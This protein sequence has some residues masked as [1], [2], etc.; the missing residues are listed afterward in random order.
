MTTKGA[1]A[2]TP[3]TRQIFANVSHH[4]GSS[5]LPAGGSCPPSPGTRGPTGE[6]R[7]AE[8]GAERE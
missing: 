1:F 4:P 7:M 2:R 5:E 8:L 6:A 3:A